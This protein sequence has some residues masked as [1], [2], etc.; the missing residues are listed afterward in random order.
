MH[1]IVDEDEEESEEPI[2][3]MLDSG[4]TVTLGKD[5]EL[6]TSISDLDRKVRM[7]TNAGS[8]HINQQGCWRGYGHA[9]YMPSAMTNIVSLSDAVEKGFTVFMDTALDNAFYVTDSQRR[10]IRF[11][12]NEEGLYTN[13][14]GRTFKSLDKNGAIVMMNMIKGFTPRQVARAIRAK[15]LY[16]DLHAETADNLKV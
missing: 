16:H 11:P 2:E 5:K 7:K 13:E 9:Y 10:T 3:M 15:K 1:S 4:S 14:T 12:C 6:F 8:K